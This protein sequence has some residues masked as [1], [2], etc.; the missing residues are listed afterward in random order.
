MKKAVKSIFSNETSGFFVG[1]ELCSRFEIAGWKWTQVERREGHPLTGQQPLL[2]SPLPCYLT[3]RI[4]GR[5]VCP[6]RVEHARPRL[7]YALITRSIIRVVTLWPAAPPCRD[8]LQLGC[9][10][11]SEGGWSQPF[12]CPTHLPPGGT[13]C[14]RGVL[15]A[16]AARAVGSLRS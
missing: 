9:T 10:H 2:F 14:V 8:A 16:L 15:M 6:C 11:A 13:G 12:V 7:V 5:L 1:S 3:F 4:I